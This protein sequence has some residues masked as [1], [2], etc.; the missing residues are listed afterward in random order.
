M[1]SPADDTEV[2]PPAGRAPTALPAAAPAGAFLALVLLGLGVVA[3]RDT[4]VALQWLHGAPWIDAVIAGIADLRFAWWMI[5][6]GIAALAIGAVLVV[7]AVRPPRKTAL[8]VN[9]KSSVWISPW[10]LAGVSTYAA[11]AIPGVFSART[12]ATPRKLVVSARV[13]DAETI[14]AKSAEV[15]TA[16]LSAIR[17]VVNPPT[18]T[19]HLTGGPAS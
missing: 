14:D 3:L 9:A 12:A 11:N 19:V 5:P 2:V 17:F 4:A 10:E 6:A 18:V 8:A 15:E 13:T 16:V 7:S 1:S